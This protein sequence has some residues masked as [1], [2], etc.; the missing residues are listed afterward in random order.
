MNLRP[1]PQTDNIEE[2]KSWCW[3]VYNFLKYPSFHVVHFVPR[4]DRTGYQEGDMFYDSDVDKVKFR[5]AS[6]W[7]T[8][9][10]S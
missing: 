1:P 4:A 8:I 10:S 6:D 2:L 5:T 9:T 7:E 3:E